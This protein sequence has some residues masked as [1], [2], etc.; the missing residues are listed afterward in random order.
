M[1]IY[2]LCSECL[3]NR[4]PLMPLS[5][6]KAGEMVNIMEITGGRDARGRLSSMGLRP[7]DLIEIINNNGRGRLILGHGD[8][9][10]AMGRGIAHKIMVSL[11]RQNH[12][13]V[14]P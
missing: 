4:R 11:A 6:A 2:G 9:R 12:K 7:G 14:K 13:A 10:L 3:D 5:M 1:E 8:M